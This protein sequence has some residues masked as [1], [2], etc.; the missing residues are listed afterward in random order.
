[1]RRVLLQSKSLPQWDKIQTSFSSRLLRLECLRTLDRYRVLGQFSDEALANQ[2]GRLEKYLSSI[3]ILPLTDH[4]LRRAEEP[5]AT[6]VGSLDSIHL[7][8]ALA[9]QEMHGR[10]FLLATHDQA[11]ALAGRAHGLDVIGV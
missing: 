2:R 7:A 5:F 10:T 6:S 8:T 3:G 1:M 4:I 9:W 11:L